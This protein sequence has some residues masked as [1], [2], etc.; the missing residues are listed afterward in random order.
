MTT[1]PTLAA[2]RKSKDGLV[3]GCIGESPTEMN[4]FRLMG[5]MKADATIAATNMKLKGMSTISALRYCL[6]TTT[7]VW[8]KKISISPRRIGKPSKY[9]PMAMPAY[10]A[11]YSRKSLMPMG[12][13][14]NIALRLPNCFLVAS[15]SPSPAH[16]PSL[17]AAS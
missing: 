8:I 15:P 3:Y 12:I 1:A 13:A 14:A 11:T 4:S 6:P 10:S 9:R 2:R 16:V 7:A 5:N 17:P